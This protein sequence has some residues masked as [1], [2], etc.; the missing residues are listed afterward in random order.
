MLSLANNVSGASYTPF[1]S[2]RSLTLDGD[3]DY[4]NTGRTFA[5]TFAGAFTISLWIKP[6]DGNPSSDEYLFG[7]QNSSG[8]DLIWGRLEDD[9]KLLFYFKSNNSD[10]ISVITD[11]AVFSDGTGVWKHVVFTAA[12]SGSD[13]TTFALYVDSS[14]VAVT[15][16]NL[17]AETDH[18][19]FDTDTHFWVGDRNLNGSQSGSFAGGI[20][21]FAIWSS[22][23][24]ANAV[25]AL[26]NN[27]NPTELTTVK[28]N[29]TAQ[30]DLVA[31]WRMGDG[32]FDDLDQSGNSG[33]LAAG[34][35]TDQHNHGFGSD[36]FDSGVGTFDSGT[37]S[38]AVY[39]TNS[40]ANVSNQLVITYVDNEQGASLEFANAKDLSSNLTVNK[41]YIVQLD[42]K[43]NG[44]SSSKYIQVYSGSSDWGTSKSDNLTTTMATYRLYFHCGHA[45]NAYIRP[46]TMDAG[47]TVTI[48]NISIREVNGYPGL[49]RGQV[50]SFS[51]D[52][53]NEF[54]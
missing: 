6:N 32:S 47:S 41:T 48:D 18:D 44:G 15:Q 23:L 33:T 43:S 8:Q 45:T 54:N 12:L 1:S 17:I 40:V 14:A 3:N 10:T 38:W 46:R 27:G 26:Y 5:T 28:G 21:E 25:T 50:T 30:G 20:D 4:I 9:G 19:D 29:Y 34:F 52:F 22:A 53:S 2:T 42:A 24:S 49:I 11:A 16:T 37:G 39:G 7:S 35:I 36:L 13:N 51:N 31:W